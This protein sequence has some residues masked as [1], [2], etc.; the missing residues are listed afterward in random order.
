MCQKKVAKG[1]ALAHEDF[2]NRIHKIHPNIK[3]IGKDQTSNK[4]IKC[5]CL[6][7]GHEWS[8]YASQLNTSRCPVCSGMTVKRGINDMWTSNPKLAKLLLNKNDGYNY[9]QFSNKKVDFKCCCGMIYNRKISDVNS[10]GLSCQ[11]CSDGISIPNKFMMNILKSLNISFN[12][13]A[14]FMW[15]DK[16]RY[17]FYIEEYNMII[18][19][20]GSQH[21][22]QNGFNSLGDRTLIEEQ[23][24]DK[25]KLDLAKSNG[26]DAYITINCSDTSYRYMYKSLMSSIL[27]TVLDLEKVDLKQCYTES[28]SS[29]LVE[30]CNLFN[31]GRSKEYILSKLH[32]SNATYYEY[33]NSGAKI[34]ICNYNKKCGKP[35]PLGVGWIAWF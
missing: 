31:T 19:M 35:T 33:L 24:N 15:S 34:G 16:K 1:K 18:E 22:E 8:P 23:K 29:K 9:T 7:D 32:I 12:S 17:D 25:Y 26:I 14:S 6:I 21:Y 10:F 13:E 28:L 4:R 5:L 3:V 30:A 2:L 27:K 11:R 20:H